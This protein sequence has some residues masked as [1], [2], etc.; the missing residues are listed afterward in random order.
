MDIGIKLE[1][2]RL[3]RGCSC[4]DQFE[5]KPAPQ[6]DPWIDRFIARLSAL[7]AKIK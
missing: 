7:L 4:L 6:H 5:P 1:Q 3:A 2:E